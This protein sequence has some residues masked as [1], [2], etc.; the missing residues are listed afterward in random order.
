MT[1][2]PK[3]DDWSAHFDLTYDAWNRLVTVE[4]GED[5]VAEYQ[6]DARNFRVLKK[7]Y[8]GGELD[9][10]RHFLYNRRWQ[11][12]EERVDTSTDADR[13]FIWGQRYIDDLVLRDRDTSEPKNGALHERLYALQDANW[14][15]VAVVSESS[16][17]QERFVYGAFGKATRLSDGYAVSAGSDL[18][19]EFRYTGE[20]L[21]AESDWLLYRARYFVPA[22]GRFA[23][24]DPLRFGQGMS[25]YRYITN[26]PLS[27]TDPSGLCA[28]GA[29]GGGILGAHDAYCKAAGTDP[30]ADG[31]AR[32]NKCFCEVTANV[33]VI[34]GQK[35]RPIDSFGCLLWESK[36]NKWLGCMGQ[37][38]FAFWQNWQA[39]LAGQA[40]E[41][42]DLAI[43]AG[44]FT[45]FMPPG[46]PQPNECWGSTLSMSFVKPD[47]SQV[48]GTLSNLCA[49]PNS[50]E[51]CYAIST[52]EKHS[53]SH[54]FRKCN[55]LQ[56]VTAR[57]TAF[58]DY[59]NRDVPHDCLKNFALF[60]KLAGIPYRYDGSLT[61]QI[62]DSK[63]VCCDDP[64]WINDPPYMERLPDDPI[65]G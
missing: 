29:T 49:N 64:F 62:A 45:G 34:M 3:A 37:C 48:N 26:R 28:V 42:V 15:V 36:C 47:G 8:D 18:D 20:R 31:M 13:H 54:C 35:W 53:L 24:R 44:P 60:P 57:I 40:Y 56:I 12:L 50:R 39:S 5:L 14:N 16:V 7:L 25:F 22:T 59:R 17:I 55:A 58:G 65:Y 52:C 9:E 27:A 33:A 23:S 61:Q 19:W 46:N 38:I 11:C 1:R 6:Y 10:T 63:N 51:C 2:I 41:D 32:A 4:D 21:D 30:S 43:P